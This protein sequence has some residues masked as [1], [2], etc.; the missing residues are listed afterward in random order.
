MKLT[1]AQYE[2]IA[3]STYL[4]TGGAGFIGSHITEFLL[5]AGARKVRVLDNMSTG[6]FRNMA[7]FANHSHFEFA[8]GDICNVDT[9]R[10]ACQGMD[11]VIQEATLGP[12]TIPM[13]DAIT[14]GSVDASGFLNILVAA[15]EAKVK[16]FVY[17]SS[18]CTYGS[19]ETPK[20]E[21]KTGE[22]Y[23]DEQYAALFTRLYGMETIG[24]RYFNVFGQRQDPQSEYAADIPKFV[25]Q[26]MRHETPA[27][28]GTC[29]NAHDFTYVEN[30]VQANILALLTSNPQ[31]VNQ[32]Y[33]IGVDERT[34]LDQLALCL[35]EYLSAFDIS[36]NN[37][38]IAQKY[39]LNDSL[40]PA[41][42]MDK[43]R[44]L[45]GY[46]PGYSLRNGLLKSVS[47]YWAYLPLCKKEIEEK[48]HR[49]QL[50]SAL[51]A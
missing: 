22:T 47:W 41:S 35:R 5:N 6:H 4:V 13:N 12:I 37:V 48:S 30:V 51:S 42:F 16:R 24:L 8:E 14:P 26:F 25:M 36:I 39:K 33:N 2:K 31:A 46:T 19:E 18:F 3:G 15:Y 45:L 9:C 10:V 1:A 34:S 11:Y 49:T 32:V 27:I 50:T 21:K 23:I 44:K 17:A 38:Q 7:P 40:H 29:E 43:A 20:T 28:N